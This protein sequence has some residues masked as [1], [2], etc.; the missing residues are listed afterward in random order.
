M[1]NLDLKHLPDTM[2][3]PKAWLRAGILLVV[4]GA[5]LVG[6]LVMVVNREPT[7]WF[8]AIFFGLSTI[9]FVWA[10]I[11]RS[12]VD[13]DRDGFSVRSLFA[14]HRYAWRDVSEFSRG[15]VGR[16]QMFLF[17]DLARKDGALAKFNRF[18]SGYNAGFPAAFIGG[19]RAQTCALLNAFRARALAR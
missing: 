4:A 1:T 13:L 7:G 3:L 2:S 17:N 12:G 19:S 15:R 6:G 5:L 14:T 11:A 18:M 8:M 9:V 16:A 10:L